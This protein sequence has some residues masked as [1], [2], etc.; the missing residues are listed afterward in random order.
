MCVYQIHTMCSESVDVFNMAHVCHIASRSIAGNARIQ[1][2]PNK[3]VCVCYGTHKK[4]FVFHPPNVVKRV[5]ARARN[6]LS[7]A[8]TSKS[9]SIVSVLLRRTSSFFHS[10]PFWVLGGVAWC[11]SR[12]PSIFSITSNFTFRLSNAILCAPCAPIVRYML[13]VYV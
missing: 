3:C 4:P 2:L 13:Y 5:S 6:F 12:V 1:P 8:A 11:I 7:T 9:E 10:S